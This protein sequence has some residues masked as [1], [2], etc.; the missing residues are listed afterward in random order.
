MKGDS[1]WDISDRSLYAIV[2]G[3]L[4][5]GCL[6]PETGYLGIFYEYR[7]GEI[8]GEGEGLDH[9]CSDSPL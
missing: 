8:V 3:E 2:F 5:E 6:Y 7:S 1:L 9:F 4:P